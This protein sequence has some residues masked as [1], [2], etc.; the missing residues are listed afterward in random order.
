[1]PQLTASAVGNTNSGY[2]GIPI[3]LLLF[4]PALFSGYILA[5]FGILAFMLTVGYCLYDD[6]A[7][8]IDQA[9]LSLLKL[10]AFYALVIG[11]GVSLSGFTF[12]PMARSIL[13]ISSDAITW[14]FSVAV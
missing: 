4:S 11:M 2:F 3:A 10:P 12:P 5:N 13:S 9:V 1:M 14:L 8:A 7:S 6:K